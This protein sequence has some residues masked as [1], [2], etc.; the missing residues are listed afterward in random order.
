MSTTVKVINLRVKG[1]KGGE[2]GD[3]Q[4]ITVNFTDTDIHTLKVGESDKYG[5]VVGMNYGF[6]TAHKITFYSAG[7]IVAE[8]D[9]NSASQLIS[10]IGNQGFAFFELGEDIQVSVSGATGHIAFLA[11]TSPY[12][13]ASKFGVIE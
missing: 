11:T 10:T 8:Y 6:T 2:I 7:T 3:I 4:Q 12:V 5:S 1:T 9:V 13:Y